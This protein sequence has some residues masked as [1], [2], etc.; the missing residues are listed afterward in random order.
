[1]LRI[2]SQSNAAVAKSYFDAAKHDY[3]L[4][5][6]ELPGVWSG[7]GAELLG[8]KGQ[9][10]K[11]QWDAVCENRNPN[12][13]DR[14]TVKD[15]HNR[16]VLYDFT[17]SAPK[18]YTLALELGG[19]TRLMGVFQQAVAE[20]MRDVEADILTRYR[21]DGEVVAE[22]PGNALMATYVHRTARP[23][24]GIP[25]CH[26]HAHAT[27][28]NATFAEGKW[29]SVEI[30]E[31][32]AQGW[33]YEAVFMARLAK[34]AAELGY[35]IKRKGRFWELEHM[36][37]SLVDKFSCRTKLIEEVAEAWGKIKAQFKAE[38]GGKTRE[39]KA[40]HISVKQLQS[41]WASRLDNKD[42]DELANLLT[43]E[44]SP[45]PTNAEAMQYA[46]AHSFERSAVIAERK[47]IEEA[48]RF[49]VGGVDLVGIQAAMQQAG[50]LVKDEQCTTETELGRERGMVQFARDGRNAFQ[51]VAL[52]AGLSAQSGGITLNDGQLAAVNHIVTSTDRITL[53]RGAAGVGKSTSL[54]LAA[55]LVRNSGRA[56]QA[57][58]L[59]NTAKDQL[60]D[61]DKGAA[62][63]A[64]FLIDKRLQQAVKGG[65]VFLDEASLVGNRQMAQLFAVLKRVDARAVLVG[66]IRQH[67][68]VEA[69]S[70]F[71]ALQK[72]SGLKVAEITEV[73][74]QKGAYK[75]VSERLS[76]GKSEQAIDLLDQLGWV[77]EADYTERMRLI[78][79]EY[80][81]AVKGK[82][83]V[84]VVAPTHAEGHSV[85]QAIREALKKDG[86]IK[87]DEREFKR[88][89]SLNLTE[90]E[91]GKAELYESGLTAQFVRASGHH[92]AG[93]RVIVGG[94]NI[95]DL[96]GR[97]GK[98]RLYREETIR[99][100]PG[101]SIRVTATAKDITGNHKLT[102]GAVYTVTGFGRG[103]AIKLSNG[104]DL[105]A[106]VGHIA[107]A[108][109]STSHSSQGR[110]VDRVLVDMPVSSFAAASMESF[111]VSATRG[112]TDVFVFTDD[113]KALREV[114]AKERVKANAQDLFPPDAAAAIPAKPLNPLKTRSLFVTRIKQIASKIRKQVSQ[115]T[116]KKEQ[117]NGYER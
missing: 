98:H 81:E 85:N 28:L 10:T 43:Q 83:S 18:S 45:L 54:K 42:R 71:R 39:H 40:P 104:W 48:L 20:T 108:Y 67:S 66:D 9:V 60:L 102:T 65:V 14:L 4:E 96:A 74:R 93:Q 78:A 55:D 6:Q 46:I 3:Y 77:T 97:A 86:R 59:S 115:L 105:S 76:V 8:L 47:L 100:A 69:G 27:V 114:A 57:I 38:V 70:P 32:K 17:W 62:T 23:V 107:Y 19:D 113:A 82:K 92:A 26:L 95:H 29:R 21:V 68:A 58:A 22:K 117:D 112:K 16:R 35:G 1:M 34:G 90:A 75:S 52:D 36:S 103:G 84:L 7:G 110:T 89:V 64:R 109:S 61:V 2:T 13:G 25:D 49:G 51:P 99:L 5:G 12:T 11:A 111:Y 24:G 15:Q 30:G 79:S 50:V 106:D 101:D 63:V 31:I 94:T 56:V 72:W 53:V 44:N 80:L 88:L 91:Q 33:Y 41:L 116:H 73:V 87:D 37:G